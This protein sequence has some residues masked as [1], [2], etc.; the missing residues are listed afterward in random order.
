MGLSASNNLLK[1]IPHKSAP[2]AYASVGSRHHPGDNQDTSPW[3][4][5]TAAISKAII[6]WMVVKKESKW[7]HL[8]AGLWLPGHEAKV[9]LQGSS[10]P[11][12]DPDITR[13][14]ET[15]RDWRLDGYFCYLVLNISFNQQ[16]Q[17]HPQPILQDSHRKWFTWPKYFSLQAQVCLTQRTCCH[18][19]R[20]E[21]KLWFDENRHY[22]KRILFVFLGTVGFWH[23]SVVELL[24]GAI[25]WWDL[26]SERTV[27]G[28]ELM[29][30]YSH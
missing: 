19:N 8:H 2:V 18:C 3:M 5:S 12:E 15:G 22:W 25:C 13:Q 16:I 28:S 17:K 10:I 21:A 20:Q 4:C 23:L 7:L 11:S 24:E 6:M 30:V 29:E 27:W 14:R 9:R 1:E 26:L